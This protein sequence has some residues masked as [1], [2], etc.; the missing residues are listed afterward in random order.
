MGASAVICSCPTL[1]P[2]CN[3]TCWAAQCTLRHTALLKVGAAG[4]TAWVLPISWDGPTSSDCGGSHNPSSKTCNCSTNRRAARFAGAFSWVAGLVHVCCRQYAT[5][6]YTPPKSVGTK[7][8]IRTAG[9]TFAQRCGCLQ[10]CLHEG[11][12][13][14]H[15]HSCCCCSWIRLWRTLP[16]HS[17]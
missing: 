9:D 7:V 10:G 14:L 8:L 11:Y 3:S 15:A 6:L 13:L 2:G 17:P 5:P 12:K 16:Q 1:L 4:E